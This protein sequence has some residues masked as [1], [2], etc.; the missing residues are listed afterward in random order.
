[1]DY[2]LQAADPAHPTVYL[3]IV[4]LTGAFD[5]GLAG[6]RR[7]IAA[8]IRASSL[9]RIEAIN[10]YVSVSVR[11]TGTPNAILSQLEFERKRFS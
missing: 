7:P 1:V 8:L 3:L 9:A 6:S 4:I 11:R 10:Q 5:C 2:D